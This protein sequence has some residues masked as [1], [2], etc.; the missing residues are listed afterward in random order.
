MHEAMR[1][2][3]QNPEFELLCVYCGNTAETWDHVVGLVKNSTFSGFG[4]VVGNLVPCCKSCN[5]KKGNKSYEDY[6][7]IPEINLL[8]GATLRQA[9]LKNYI[10][11]YS[12]YFEKNSVPAHPD[13]I[14]R[15]ELVK[16]KILLLLKEGDK[17][18]EEIRKG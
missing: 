15:L 9:A 11:K 6:F 8:P 7:A 14:K 12:E 17:I 10:E 4:H 5:Q 16:E 1:V 18:T 2:L 3:G 13:K